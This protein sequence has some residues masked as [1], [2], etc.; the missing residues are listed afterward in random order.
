MDFQMNLQMWSVLYQFSDAES[1]EDGGQNFG[2]LD[3]IVSKTEE[4]S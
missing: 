1:D 3:K 2:N 4:T